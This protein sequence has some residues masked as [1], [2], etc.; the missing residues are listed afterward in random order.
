MRNIILLFLTIL[1]LGITQAQN[2]LP[3][4]SKTYTFGLLK[5]YYQDINKIAKYPGLQLTLEK[6]NWLLIYQFL[7]HQL[8]MRELSGYCDYVGIP[9]ERYYYQ[10]ALNYLIIKNDK[11]IISSGFNLRIMLGQYTIFC[12]D[13]GIWHEPVVL[14]KRSIEPGLNTNLLYFPFSNKKLSKIGF[15][16]NI[17]LMA[18]GANTYQMGICYKHN[19]KK[20]IK[21]K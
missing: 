19:S 9:F 16:T 18:L 8:Y 3:I 15:S 7:P 4:K 1:G 17:N 6:K 2:V 10:F 20:S 13:K 11:L 21:K 5:N 14:P 12:L